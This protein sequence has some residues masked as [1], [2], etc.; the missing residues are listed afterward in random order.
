MGGDE[1][2]CFIE[3]E[4]LQDAVGIADRILASLRAPIR[5]AGRDIFTSTSIGIAHIDERYKSSVDVI[6]DAD[7]AMYRAKSSG[8]M[9]FE[10]FHETM[11]EQALATLRLEMDLRIAMA[12][13]EF[14]LHYQP[15]VNI[16]DGRVYGFEALVRWRHA[17]RGLI[18]PAE[19]IPLAEET[20]LIV[21]LG[22]WV[23]GEACR[24]MSAW[25]ALGE[26]NANLIIS[27]NV[28][29]RQLNDAR[30]FFEL[31]A[32]LART[33]LAPATL[34]LELTESIL[35]QNAEGARASLER[36]RRLGV[37][38]ALDDFG[39]GYSSLSYLEKFPID[40]LKI[41]QSFVARLTT[42]PTTKE[43]V[44]L[45]VGLGSALEMNV[46][47]EGVE[48]AAQWNVLRD[49]GCAS[50]QGYL[51]SRPVPE[52]DVPGL[53]GRELG[54]RAPAKCEVPRALAE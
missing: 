11:H 42:A 14:Q 19:F 43:I 48:Q 49:F 27:V 45:I 23:L 51:F 15:L 26:D 41:D 21:A 47:A 17:E 3:A 35:L 22:T 31:E 46:L 37:R 50:A 33:G 36:I 18:S 40:T 44:R 25:H 20:G 2:V 29:S 28:S 6:R 13:S 34:Q 10:L 24:Q 53:L 54:G 12:R 39:T 1:F 52:A 4:Q 5:L 16:R 38:I 9:R 8:G 32:A 7:T 30:F